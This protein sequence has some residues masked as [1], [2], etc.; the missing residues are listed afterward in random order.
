MLHWALTSFVSVQALSGTR[1]RHVLVSACC[2]TSRAAQSFTCIDHEIAWA[3]S[4]PQGP[5]MAHEFDL[6]VENAQVRMQHRFAPQASASRSFCRQILQL[7]KRR[8]RAPVTHD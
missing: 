4:P 6:L 5:S 2:H 8:Q 1:P 3:V 7:S